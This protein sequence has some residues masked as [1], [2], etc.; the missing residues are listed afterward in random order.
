MLLNNKL[1]LIEAPILIPGVRAITSTRDGGVSESPFNSLNLGRHVGDDLQKVRQNRNLLQEELPGDQISWIKQVH[2]ERVV[3]GC[4]SDFPEAD[5]QWTSDR[6]L[7][8]AI[9][10]ADC[11]PVVVADNTGSFV[12]V[13]HAGWRGLASELLQSLIFELPVKPNALSVW[14][15]P[16]ISQPFYEIGED[17]RSTIISSVGPDV[18]SAFNRA[19]SG[20]WQ[21]D[22][23]L[24]ARC[25]L[26]KLGVLSITGGNWC[27]ASRSDLFFSHRRDSARTGRMATVIWL[28]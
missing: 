23:Y 13:A 27:T 15:G 22:L 7:P 16:A 21:A 3:R 12:G 18:S 20:K 2:G 4:P 28:D 9:L 10:T 6:K 8:L 19:G 17:V 5:A 14:L 25:I 26:T 1:K 11:L 24:V